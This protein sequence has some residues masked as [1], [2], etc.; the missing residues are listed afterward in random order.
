MAITFPLSLPTVTGFMSIELSAESAV[1]ISR[2]PFSYKSQIQVNQGRMW[3]AEVS[4]PIMERSKAEEWISF[5]LKLNGPEGT[6]FMGDPKGATARGSASSAPGTPVVKGGSQTGGTL[7]IDGLPAATTGYFLAGDYFQLGT[8]AS[9]RLYKV[10]DNTNA[11]STG[12]ATID[13][14]PDLRS[15]PLD[16]A[17]LVVSSPVTRW[18]LSRNVATWSVDTAA[19]YGI[20]FSAEEAI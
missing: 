12:D 3:R 8:S 14:W 17:A 11:G 10:L 19:F 20:T 5:Q 18:R 9:S 13:I 6:F 2:S 1:A 16:N 7:I 4:L 15:T